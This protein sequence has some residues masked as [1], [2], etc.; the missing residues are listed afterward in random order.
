[1]EYRQGELIMAWTGIMDEEPRIA[2]ASIAV[3][4]DQ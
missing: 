1:M 3:R 4:F 2:T